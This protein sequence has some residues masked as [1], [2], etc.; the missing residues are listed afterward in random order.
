MTQTPKKLLR[1][2]VPD[3]DCPVE[4]GQIERA[5]KDNPVV[6]EMR[7]DTAS[8]TAE[9]VVTAEASAADIQKAVM[10]TGMESTVLSEEPLNEA[11]CGRRLRLLVPH[12]RCPA[13]TGQIERALA[14]NADIISM[15]FDTALRTASF[16]LTETADPARIRATIEALGMPCEELAED[17]RSEV[18][19]RVENMKSDADVDAVLGLIGLDAAVDKTGRTLRFQIEGERAFA[20]LE[21]LSAAG[22]EASIVRVGKPRSAAPET[23]IPWGR[24]GLGLVLAAAAEVLELWGG[25]PQWAIIAC[26]AAAILLAG[27][28]TIKKGLLCLVRLIF[29][30]STLMSVAVVGAAVLG[31]WPEAAMVMVL[32]EIGEAIES[33]SMV[34]AKNAIRGLL[35]V[36]PETVLA[37]IQNTWKR[38]PAQSVPAGTVFRTEP[39]ER[40][41]LDGV[42]IEGTGAMDES[43]ITGESMP[44]AKQPGSRVFAGA[45]TLEAALTVR[46]TAAASDSMSARIIRSV[47][48]AEQKKAPLQRFVDRFAARYTP[49]V[50]ALALATAVLGP[51]VTHDPWVTWIYRALV[52]LVIACPCALVISTP[53]TI[54][55]ALSLAARRGI[56]IKGGVYLEEGRNLRNVALDKTGTITRGKPVFDR[57]VAISPA[58]AGRALGLGASLAAMSSHPVSRAIAEKGQAEGLEPLLVKEFKAL[59]GYGTE[60]VVE[61]ARIRLTNLRWLEEH[62]VAD[63]AVRRAFDEAYREGKSAAALSDMFGV[64]AVFIV[65]DTLKPNAARAIA[66]MKAAGLTPWLLTGDNARAA[67]TIAA[68]AGIEHVRADLLPEQKL[69]EIERLEAEAPTAMAGDGIND[70]PALTRARIGFAMGIKG[71]DTAIEAADVALMDDDIEK[72]AWFKRLS[73]LTH[74]TLIENIVFA[75]S[76]KV[77]FALLALAGYASMWMAVFADTGVCLIVVAWGLRLMKASAKVDRMVGA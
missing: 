54:V 6:L 37:S 56:L 27:L 39:G 51:L 61:G 59:P 8:R 62:G 35:D 5:L 33:M 66:A 58:A 30:M 68:Q 60:G 63:A 42:V 69:A 50:F 7:F 15:R 20:L 4:T 32:F 71:A 64:L 36:A 52:L 77:V 55:S 47:E 29:N 19:M 45:L 25:A 74:R 10:Q 26:S 28:G 12:T 23:R 44:A 65:A 2:R 76:V 73:E 41:A 31:A 72:I 21:K 22:W 67:Q 40:A 34:R 24:L 70:A 53:V 11:P 49:T 17:V 57:A 75:L 9:F 18:T 13:E 46:A 38:V 48:E 16:V 3:M 43:M 14:D 1:L